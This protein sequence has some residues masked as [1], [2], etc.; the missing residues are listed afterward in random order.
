[1]LSKST[2]TPSQEIY[3]IYNPNNG[4]HFFTASSYE[5]GHLKS[6][7]RAA[8]GIGWV[9]LQSGDPV[10]RVYNR[11]SGEHLYTLNWN[12]MDM[13]SKISWDPEGVAW[14]SPNSGLL[15][16]RVYNPNAKGTQEARYASLHPQCV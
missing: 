6:L 11:N 8:E 5:Y 1:M 10:Y 9:A 3:C 16:H 15:L 4:E 14:Y 2:F 7:G 13:L 12:E